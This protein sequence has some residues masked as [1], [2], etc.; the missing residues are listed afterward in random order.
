MTH[1][2]QRF[3][4]G[5][6]GWV[7]IRLLVISLIVGLVLSA[8]NI[9]PLD[10]AYRLQDMVFSLWDRGFDAVAVAGRWLVLGAIVVIPIWL[11]LRILNMGRRGPY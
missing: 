9:H 7:L 1:A 3:F 6:P 2:L 10:I 11:I 4:G 5:P 8:L